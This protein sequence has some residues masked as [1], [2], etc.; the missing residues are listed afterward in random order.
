MRKSTAVL[1]L[2]VC[3]V[4]LGVAWQL[5][6]GVANAA[7]QQVTVTGQ[8]VDLACYARDKANTGMHHDRGRECAWACVRWEAHPVGLLTS[9]GKVYQLAGAIVADS[10]VKIA[11]HLGQT[12]TATGQVSEKDGMQM[13]TTSEVKAAGSVR[14]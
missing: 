14:N 13:L 9:S 6:G 4:V 2:A 7:Q 10:N 3:A 12:V 5:R 11:P 1:I 8:V